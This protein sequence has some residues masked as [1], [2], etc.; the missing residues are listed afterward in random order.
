MSGLVGKSCDILVVVVVLVGGPLLKADGFPI[1]KPGSTGGQNPEQIRFRLDAF[2][3][4]LD[5]EIRR[6]RMAQECVRRG[7]PLS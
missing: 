1:S 4:W 2:G 7:C 3:F 6:A 5:A